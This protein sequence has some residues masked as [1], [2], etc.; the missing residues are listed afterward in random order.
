MKLLKTLFS[1]LIIIVFLN[2]SAQTDFQEKIKQNEKKLGEIKKQ[3]NIVKS[4]KDSI[5]IQRSKTLLVLNRMDDEIHLTDLLINEMERR[6]SLLTTRITILGIEIDSLEIELVIRKKAL[7][8]R[9][10]SLYKKG[11][12]VSFPHPTLFFLRKGRF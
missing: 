9:I 8:K 5:N 12:S 4:K 6:D 1:F 11:T 10:V 7:K 2:V 3:L